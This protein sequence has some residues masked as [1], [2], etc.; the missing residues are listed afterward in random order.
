MDF[1]QPQSPKTKISDTSDNSVTNS[2]ADKL[3]VMGGRVKNTSAIGAIAQPQVK[4]EANPE[5]LHTVTDTQNKSKSGTD[6]LENKKTSNTKQNVKNSADTKP[7]EPLKYADLSID[8]NDIKNKSVNALL[9]LC[10][11]LKINVAAHA[12]KSDL[13]LNVL[14]YYSRNGATLHSTGV[15]EVMND[16]FG[17]LRYLTDNIDISADSVYVSPNQIRRF[18][19]RT[20]QK[21]YGT[22]RCP[23]SN[24]KYCAMLKI[25]K[26]NDLEPNDLRKV[27][28]FRHL[29]PIFPN[30][31]LSLELGDGSNG[32]ITGRIVDLIAPIGKGQ[33]ALI[34]SPPKAGKTQILKRIARAITTNNPECNLLVLLIDERPEEVTDM[35]RSVKGE[36]SSQYF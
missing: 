17:F 22:M 15:L 25:L 21:I 24:E 29:T 26:V 1:E 5:E 28:P 20:G 23:K 31:R 34:V 14:R 3:N 2:P 32:D 9:D 4:D 11:E 7:P 35:Q 13:L 8:L 19:L 18:G 16:G 30:E 27:I 10:S 12:K 6:S 33:R 36:S